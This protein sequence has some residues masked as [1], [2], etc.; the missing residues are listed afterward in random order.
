MVYLAYR[1][2]FK[3]ELAKL[4]KR[5]KIRNVVG[6]HRDHLYYKQLADSIDS[7]KTCKI[8]GDLLAMR[9]FESDSVA[10]ANFPTL[11]SPRDDTALIVKCVEDGFK[12]G[13][14]PRDETNPNAPPFLDIL[15][16]PDTSMPN[17]SSPVKAS[18]RNRF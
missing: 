10:K 6:K 5:T 4:R 9:L 16:P 7:E 12:G 14:R 15:R 3:D 1:N 18:G 11:F 2:I 8:L 13:Y 17:G